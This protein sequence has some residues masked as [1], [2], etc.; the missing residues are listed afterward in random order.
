[1]TIQTPESGVDTGLPDT[2]MQSLEN[3]SNDALRVTYLMDM[4]REIHDTKQLRTMFDLCADLARDL[5]NKA[6]EV[7]HL[8][9]KAGN[10]QAGTM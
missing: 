10:S 7:V 8:A 9:M 6:D 4:V 1:M 3:L 5:A 2:F